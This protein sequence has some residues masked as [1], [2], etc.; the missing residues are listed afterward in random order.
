MSSSAVRTATLTAHPCPRDRRVVRSPQGIDQELKQA[1]EDV[2]QSSVDVVSGSVR[3]WAEKV[4]MT[5]ALDNDPVGP[6]GQP[7]LPRINYSQEGYWASARAAQSI[8]DSLPVL[9]ERQVHEVATR[10]R[11][12]IEDERTVSVLLKHV[13]D[14]IVED[15]AVFN[16]LVSN[17]YNGALR[18]KG[19]TEEYIREKIT[20]GCKEDWQ[21][22]HLVA[23]SS[24]V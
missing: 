12:Y 14:K 24:S 15:Y 22:D 16:E 10:L 6:D 18:G 17:L 13:Q 21:S 1:C 9:L 2:I 23:G 4:R 8:I 11:L 3:S 19:P 7:A 20:R 5:H